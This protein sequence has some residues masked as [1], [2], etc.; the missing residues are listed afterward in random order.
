MDA[1]WLA[2]AGRDEVTRTL[3]ASGSLLRRAYIERPRGHSKTTDTAVQLAWILQAATSKVTGVAA[4]ADQDQAAIIH[5]AVADLVRHNPDLC[6]DLDV[7]KWSI[8]NRRT[9]SEL[10]VITSDVSSSWG[11]LPDFV[12]CDELCHWPSPDLWHSLCSSAAKKPQALLIVLTNAGVGTGWQWEVREAARTSPDWH[13]STL[14]GSQAP[15]I[16]AATLAEQRR[17]LPPAV[18]ARLWDNV[19]QHS[20]GEFVTLAEA[21]ACRDEALS[22][23]DRGRPQFEYVA[24]V[25]YAEKHDR[26]VGVVVH[27]EGERL[28]VDR[29]DVVAPSPGH[30]VLVQW[31]E[32]WLHEIAANFPGV[33]FVLDEYQLLG[34]IQRLSGR[35]SI[36]PFD[37]A[38]GR[39]NHALAMTLRN[40]IVHRHVRWYPGCG[41]L[42]DTATRDDLE[43]ELAS[44]VLRNLSAT[45]VRIDHRREAGRH[46]DRAFALGAA[47]LELVRDQRGEGWL[48]FTPP[49]VRMPGRRD[50]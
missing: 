33:R 34:V 22:I 23:K 27:R 20:D 17:L 15:W 42:P 11:Q 29:M 37:F 9:G 41:Q 49:R 36:E 7:L 39:G 38:A 18:Y 50:A 19:W 26:T 8:R 45:R 48:T 4:A 10:Q 25:D 3:G 30:P 31:V 40:L 35:L 28:I 47:C 32:D 1:A 16:T 44:L 46:D 6:R 2:L 5:R 13:F 12:I 14:A 43:T 21:E 24:A